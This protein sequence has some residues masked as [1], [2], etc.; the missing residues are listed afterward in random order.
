MASSAA[1]GDPGNESLAR[2]GAPRAVSRLLV[3]LDEAVPEPVRGYPQVGVRGELLRHADDGG[4]T[5]S[6]GRQRNLRRGRGP[7]RALR[8]IAAACRRRRWAGKSARGPM[9]LRTGSG[10][11]KERKRAA[12]AAKVLPP[13]TAATGDSI[14]WAKSSRVTSWRVTHTKKAR[15][16]RRARPRRRLSSSDAFSAYSAACLRERDGGAR[17]R[18]DQ[19]KD[20]GGETTWP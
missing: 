14:A 8:G 4:S 2:A 12:A 20:R 19:A 15:A 7:A 3:Q 16:A 5:S 1:L 18:R 11:A 10:A 6:G 17:E 13:Q 9:T